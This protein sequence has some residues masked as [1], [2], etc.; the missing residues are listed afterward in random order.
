MANSYFKFKQF[1]IRQDKCA[2]KVT[3]DAC[4]FGA[5]VAEN[6]LKI[7]SGLDIGAGTGLLTL[8]LAQKNPGAKIDALEIDE[9]AA[10]QAQEN[11]AASPWAGNL[12]V[13]NE[14]ALQFAKS[15]QMLASVIFMHFDKFISCKFGQ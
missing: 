8:M 13:F 7:S 3:T 12:V 14:D 15:K 4:L 9:A 11:I 10:A 2:M 5:L 1:T 6:K